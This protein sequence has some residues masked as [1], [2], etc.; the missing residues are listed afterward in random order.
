MIDEN[1]L[2]L[3]TAL[4]REEMKADTRKAIITVRAYRSDYL[5]KHGIYAFIMGS[6][7]FLILAGIYALFHLES[8]TTMV[9]TNEFMQGFNA[10]VVRFG[11]FITVFV[12]INVLVYNYKYSVCYKNFLNYRKL[13]RKLIN[14]GSEGEK[15]DQAS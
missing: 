15:D 13:Q 9:F 2:K 12:G 8:F 3:M 6:I 4:A 5:I 7:V 1:K 10:L 14:M 11:I